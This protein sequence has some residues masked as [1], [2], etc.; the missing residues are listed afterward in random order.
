MVQAVSTVSNLMYGVIHMQ[1][2]NNRSHTHTHSLTSNY[3]YATTYLDEIISLINF[4]AEIINYNYL[5][6]SYK[7]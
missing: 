4:H 6:K 2:Q 1:I 5:N 3:M 7:L